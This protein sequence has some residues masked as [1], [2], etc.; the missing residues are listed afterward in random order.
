MRGIRFHIIWLCIAVVKHCL[1]SIERV[2]MIDGI[3]QTL[4][5]SNLPADRSESREKV[6]ADFRELYY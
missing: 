1:D 5:K 3:S 4:S 6:A 2:I